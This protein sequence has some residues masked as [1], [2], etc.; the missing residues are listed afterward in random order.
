[1]RTRINFGFIPGRGRVVGFSRVL[2]RLLAFWLVATALGPLLELDYF[3]P[4]MAFTYSPRILLAMVAVVLGAVSILLKWRRLGRVHVAAGALLLL[5]SGLASWLRVAPAAQEGRIY[6]L[7]AFN[8]EDSFADAPR[9]AQIA[10]DLNADFLCLQEVSSKHREAFTSALSDYSFFWTR[11]EDPRRKLPTCVTG[12][13]TAL[14]QSRDSVELAPAITGYRTQGVRVRLGEP[15]LWIVNVHT[16]KPTWIDAPWA[17]Y[18]LKA[19]WKALWHRKERDLLESW[20][21]GR[22]DDPVIV[23]GDFNAPSLSFNTRFDGYCN[24]H[25][26]AGKGFHLTF[27]RRSPV[28]GIDNVL[29]NGRIRF[30]E[31]RTF[32]AGF[33]DHRGQVCEFRLAPKI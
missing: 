6:R 1:M 4:G 17:D 32:D 22:G 24:A 3:W 30:Q 28:L 9:L 13:R 2:L 20:L 10:R 29:G 18:I 31:Y 27:P 33:S 26:S 15:W 8:T 19:R 21:E 14:I 23:A 11:D 7:L 12:V 5:T 16:T 25:F